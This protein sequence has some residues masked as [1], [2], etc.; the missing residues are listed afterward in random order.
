VVPPRRPPLGVPRWTGEGVAV[1]LRQF[2]RR[3]T[4]GQPSPVPPTGPVR[5][6]CLVRSDKRF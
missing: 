2:W 5:R 6:Q 3:W 4:R 1:I